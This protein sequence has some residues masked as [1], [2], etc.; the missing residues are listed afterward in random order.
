MQLLV[1]VGAVNKPLY[2]NTTCYNHKEDFMS[3]VFQKTYLILTSTL[4][5]QFN[6]LFISQAIVSSKTTAILQILI[7]TFLIIR[8]CCIYRT[9]KK[10]NH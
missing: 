9:F 8:T 10:V 2:G 5:K 7:F 4:L 1:Q 6:I 3:Y